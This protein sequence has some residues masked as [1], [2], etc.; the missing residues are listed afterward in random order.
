MLGPEGAEGAKK[1]TEGKPGDGLMAWLSDGKD[2]WKGR[3]FLKK[4]SRTWKRSKQV[5]KI[6]FLVK[7]KAT[8]HQKNTAR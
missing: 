7:P 3:W 8:N 2:P 5:P 6:M 4:T 1:R